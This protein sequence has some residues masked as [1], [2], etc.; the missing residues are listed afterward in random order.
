MISEN[1]STTY[2]MRKNESAI[3]PTVNANTGNPTANS[4]ARDRRYCPLTR[5]AK[6]CILNLSLLKFKPPRHQATKSSF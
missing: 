1:P 2:T 4:T 6:L 5:F 3:P